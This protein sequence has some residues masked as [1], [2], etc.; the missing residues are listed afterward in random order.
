MLINDANPRRYTTGNGNGLDEIQQIQNSWD[1]W[2]QS[3][4]SPQKDI[5]E[6]YTD[7]LQSLGYVRFDQP[8][9]GKKYKI[10]HVENRDGTNSI[11]QGRYGEITQDV[12]EYYIGSGKVV[13][14]FT[15][16]EFGSTILT[17]EQNAIQNFIDQGGRLFL[18]GQDIG[19]DIGET[20]FYR[21]V[22]KATF[23][24]D[25]IALYNINGV[26][27]DDLSGELYNINIT[28]GDGA[29]NQKFPS[30]IDVGTG[31]SSILFYD[32][33]GSG[34]GSIESSGA[35]GIKYLAESGGAFVYFAF[36]FEGI[37]NLDG[38]NNGR[39]IVLQRVLEWL[40]APTSTGN[41]RAIPGDG[42]VTLTWTMPTDYDRILIIYKIGGYPTDGP[43]NG[44]DYNV[45]DQ[46][47]D[48]TV[49]Y[50]GAGTLYVHTQLT[51][52]I[53]YYYTGYVYKSDQSPVQYEF[54]GQDSATP[55]AEGPGPGEQLLPPTNLTATVQKPDNIY[56]IEL[57]WTDNSSDPNE[58]KFLIERKS[59][60]ETEFTQ[61]A[62]VGQNITTYT[63]DNN[64]EG[65]PLNT[66]WYYRVRGYNST[67]EN[68]YSEYSNVA[69]AVV[70]E[71]L[72]PTDLIA[73]PG[74][75]K[76]VL[77]WRDNSLNEL[78]FSIERK[79]FTPWDPNPSYTEIW[80]TDPNTT[81]FE[82]TGYG[83][84]AN[85][86]FC[87]GRPYF[88]RVR[89]IGTEVPYS[90]YSNESWAIPTAFPSNENP[91]NLQ[92]FA[93]YNSITVAWDDN[94]TNESYYYVELWQS[95]PSD[96]AYPDSTIV[97]PAFE[98]T[99][100]AETTI[101]ITYGER[102]YVRVIALHKTTGYGFSWYANSASEPDKNYVVVEPFIEEIM[103]PGGAT[104][105]CF[106]AS[107]LFGENSKEVKLLSNFR[108][109]YLLKTE[110]SRKFVKFY[111][112][113]GPGIAEFIGKNNF[114][115]IICKFIFYPVVIFAFIFVHWYIILIGAGIFLVIK[116]W[117]II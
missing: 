97:Y 108:D 23:I 5:L 74:E 27:L 3:N 47:G 61:I 35:A 46:I 73:M 49:I 45:G 113:V 66:I 32:P 51:N 20:S 96:T 38:T 71:L 89:A 33:A 81:I 1:F 115:K 82:D 116:K 9:S 65:F 7:T 21:D 84:P 77:N 53:T 40:G 94:T 15:G 31:A 24:Q 52:G 86:Y 87:D 72:P 29:D 109:K 98:G 56:V 11:G 42:Q 69:M 28:T 101:Y 37:N 62:E 103:D 6:W 34:P 100:R 55:Q 88:Y 78:G 58:E 95:V 18:T 8:G 22:L 59:S 36:G 79:H 26:K 50:N 64:G 54:L 92:G 91:K 48:G 110:P 25:N 13:I 70:A 102:W 117:R 19:Y 76:I 57:N 90:D 17:K 68:P 107:C 99:G 75:R 4:T 16:N 111:Y 85:E 39:K 106:I 41:F 14:W 104:G 93:G 105:G 114:L 44:Q 63:D 80:V 83:I 67:L 2:Y 112:R 43:T 60:T 30:E 10:W 12:L